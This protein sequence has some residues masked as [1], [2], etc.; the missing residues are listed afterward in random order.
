MAVL[1]LAFAAARAIRGLDLLAVE[2]SQ[3]ATR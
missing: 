1:D 2:T 3:A